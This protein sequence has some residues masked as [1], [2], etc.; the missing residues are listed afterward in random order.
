M[1]EIRVWSINGKI[2]TGQISSTLRR[3]CYAATLSDVINPLLTGRGSSPCLRI[4]LGIHTPEDS[5][6]SG[7]MTLSCWEDVYIISLPSVAGCISV[8]VAT[9]EKNFAVNRSVLAYTCNVN[10]CRVDGINTS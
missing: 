7:H 4:N 1:N 9:S 3:A 10:G 2:L 5:C 8:H 6:I